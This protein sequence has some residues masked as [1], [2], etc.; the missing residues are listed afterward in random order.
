[1]QLNWPTCQERNGTLE[2]LL[3][4]TMFLLKRCHDANPFSFYESK[5]WLMAKGRRFRR[6]PVNNMLN[7]G[8]KVCDTM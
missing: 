8:E 6:I 2:Y 5:L 4:S 3:Y 1:M 7:A